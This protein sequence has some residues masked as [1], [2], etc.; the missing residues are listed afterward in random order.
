[1]PSL[2]VL[3]VSY[4]RIEEILTTSSELPSICSLDLSYNG[5]SY[6]ST[7]VILN[8]VTLPPK[9]FVYSGNI[10]RAQFIAQFSGANILE[11]RQA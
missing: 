11:I 5:I 10:R 7:F 9:S 4:N 2:Q 8:R 1:M 3:D 6:Y